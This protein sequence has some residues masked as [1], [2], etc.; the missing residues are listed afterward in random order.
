MNETFAYLLFGK[1]N[2]LGAHVR[3]SSVADPLE[4]IGIVED[5][6]YASLGEDPRP[7]IFLPMTQATTRWTTLVARSSL[8]DSTVTALLRKTVL[9]LDPDITLFSAG[10]LKEQL[11]LPLFP[12]RMAAIVLGVFGVFAMALAATGLF[13]LMSLCGSTADS[14]DR[15]SHG[16]G[17]T[18]NQVLLSLLGRTLLLCAAGTG[19]GRSSHSPPAG[20]SRRFFT[21]SAR[22][23]R[24]LMA[25]RYF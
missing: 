7:A 13:A 9:D 6:K 20:C 12:A 22:A 1:E 10:G 16:A 15:N 5:G 23:I 3:V 17:R 24:P 8:P 14:R 2:P 11:A 18:A 21:A 25:R 4:V 19:L